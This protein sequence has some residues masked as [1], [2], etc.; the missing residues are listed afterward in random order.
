M[1]EAG[2]SKKGARVWGWRDYTASDPNGGEALKRKTECDDVEC[3]K[4]KESQV[5]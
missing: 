2:A 3:S 5:E 4:W 1:D